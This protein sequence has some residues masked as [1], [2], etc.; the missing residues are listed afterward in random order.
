MASP[1]STR[2]VS[3]INDDL[4][5]TPAW[6]IN[7]ILK[8]ESLFGQVLDPG[9]GTGNISVALMKR[10]YDKKQ[11]I[12]M[13]LNDHGFGL[14]GVDFLKE[15]TL[16]DNIIMNPPFNLF[17][18][19]LIHALNMATD[20][21]VVFARI[22]CLESQGRYD[23]VMKDNPPTRIYIFVNRVK[24]HKAG[25]DDGQSS[26]VMYAWMV[27]D[28]KNKGRHYSETRWIHEKKPRK[29]IIKV[30]KK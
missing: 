2:K 27:W 23:A 5:T 8:R 13:D 1:N 28:I 3:K 18:E 7:A 9:C 6:A 20:K 10:G 30:E 19:F 4:Y 24:C 26:A 25:I 16:F 22:N 29:K 12:S 17:N 11:I 14:T 21:V 15:H